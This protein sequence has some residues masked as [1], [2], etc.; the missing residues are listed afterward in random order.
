MALVSCKGAD[1]V[2]QPDVMSYR[3]LDFTKVK[4]LIRIGELEAEKYIHSIKQLVKI[5]YENLYC[6]R[7]RVC[8]GVKRAVD[9]A[10]NAVNFKMN[11]CIPLVQ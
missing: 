3:I 5:R 7:S 2:I 8:A 1:I 9:M 6:K 11:L 4:K 10:F